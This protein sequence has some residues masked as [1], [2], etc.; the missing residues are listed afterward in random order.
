MRSP[1]LFCLGAGKHRALS[2]V[3]AD[4]SFSLGP[5]RSPG[6]PRRACPE[7]FARWHPSAGVLYDL[8]SSWIRRRF[9]PTTL[10][11]R[12]G[13]PGRRSLWE[14]C[15]YL[16]TLE[17][18]SAWRAASH[19]LRGEGADV[20]PFCPLLEGERSSRGNIGL[21]GALLCVAGL[22]CGRPGRRPWPS[23]LLLSA[24]CSRWCSALRSS[25]SPSG[26]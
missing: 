19:G 6:S 8:V 3:P 7:G 20:D 25:S 18:L 24:T 13:V 5:R 16:R 26:T 1:P 9:P 11:G 15:P 17:S 2:G 21:R 10:Y 4:G 12:A 22:G 14:S 23:L